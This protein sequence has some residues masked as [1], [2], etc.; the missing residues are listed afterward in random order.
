VLYRLLSHKA[1]HHVKI[2]MKLQTN[3]KTVLSDQL[4][5]FKIFR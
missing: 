5:F 4:S 2:S 1:A 3:K